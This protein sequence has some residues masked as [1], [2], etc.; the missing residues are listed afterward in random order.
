MTNT[1][2]FLFLVS[3]PKNELLKCLCQDQPNAGLIAFS[4]V[5]GKGIFL[6]CRLLRGWQM[7]HSRCESE[8]STTLLQRNMQVKGSD[9]TLMSRASINRI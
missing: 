9:L 6:P 7:L 8:E 5:R 2:M 3:F 1:Q 4:N